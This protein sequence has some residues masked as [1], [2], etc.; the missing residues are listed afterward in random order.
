M[1]DRK[2]SLIN[3][4]DYAE[5][6]A[7]DYFKEALDYYLERNQIEKSLDFLKFKCQSTSCVITDIYQYRKILHENYIKNKNEVNLN[8]INH[9]EHMISIDTKSPKRYNV[10]FYYVVYSYYKKH[11]KT[12]FESFTY[13]WKD[14]ID[15]D[16]LDGSLYLNS[17]NSNREKYFYNL[18][19]CYCNKNLL[20]EARNY[21]ISYEKKYEEV[22]KKSSSLFFA[23]YTLSKSYYKNGQFDSARE[24]ISKLIKIDRP[25]YLLE[26]PIKNYD[27]D[28]L[29]ST[30]FLI[31]LIINESKTSPHFNNVIIKY[32]YNISITI[33]GLAYGNELNT[34]Y[35]KLI[36]SELLNYLY[37]K[38]RSNF[39]V[40]VIIKKTLQG[41][42][43]I[44]SNHKSFFVK[45]KYSLI[46][47]EMN[48]EYS[49]MKINSYDRSKNI[50]S[51]VAIIYR[52]E[53]HSE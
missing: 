45:G 42:Y 36:I 1:T 28:W 4:Y 43:F 50:P 14:A 18:V 10:G 27:V 2:K 25:N 15:L 53:N 32:L 37:M 38:S 23:Y 35:K 29:E 3:S 49:F 51:E 48:K 7:N 20:L 8:I 31:E 22:I 11:D 19:K 46:Q 5:I 6:I 40:G 41:N 13:K 16:D 34:Y 52:M 21:I 17:K 24:L 30:I 26:L 9:I 44:Y 47:V 12:Q 33:H 39:N